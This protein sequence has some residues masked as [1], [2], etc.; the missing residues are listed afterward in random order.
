MS[1]HD[2]TASS[3][4][5]PAAYPQ[6]PPPTPPPC[7][8]VVDDDFLNQRILAN[9]LKRKG[10][11]GVLAGSGSE[12]LKKLATQTFDLILLDIQMP[13]MDG[14]E[15]AERIRRLEADAGA[16]KRTPIV[17][18][19]ALRQPNTRE[20]CLASGM[21]DHLSKPVDTLRLYAVI[22]RLLDLSD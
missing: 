5:S 8:L 1:T 9:L 17:A 22:Q 10:W 18:L 13:E 16:S 7:I 19:T 21:D 20:R 6:P 14:F 11:S 2:G 15:T 3:D 4:V 12:C